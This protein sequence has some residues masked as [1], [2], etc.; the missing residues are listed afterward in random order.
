MSFGTPHT[1]CLDSRR[2]LCAEF[3]VSLD[4][5]GFVPVYSDLIGDEQPLLMV[6]FTQVF[7]ELLASS[8]GDD[9]GFPS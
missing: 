9:L 7:S 3:L 8:T 6:P 5:H 1:G 4:H 2:L